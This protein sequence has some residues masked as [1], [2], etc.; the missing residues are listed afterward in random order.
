FKGVLWHQG[1][2]DIF[3]TNTY[4]E[5]IS[6]LIH[7]IRSDLGIPDLPFIAGQLSEAKPARA[8]FNQMIIHLPERVKATGVA[9]TEGLKAFDETH[10]DSASQRLLGERYAQQMLV[11]V[12]K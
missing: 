10:F 6:E 7:S 3:N 12:R 9:T 4:L 11:F 8:D 5:N 1:E 2:A